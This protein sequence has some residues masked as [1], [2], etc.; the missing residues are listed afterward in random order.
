MEHTHSLGTFE[1]LIMA[2]I[3][4]LGEAA[5]GIKVFERVCLLAQ[6]SMYVSLKRLAKTGYLHR[7]V[8][9]SRRQRGRPRKYF[10]LLP[11]GL[12]ALLSAK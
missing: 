10:S 4:G 2:A 7:E 8:A 12:N 1:Q 11:A 3:H 9:P 5:Y 6:G